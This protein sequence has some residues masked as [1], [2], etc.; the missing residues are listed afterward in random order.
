MAEALEVATQDQPV[1]QWQSSA[2]TTNNTPGSF[3]A[4]QLYDCATIH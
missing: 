2:A 4:S 1:S 3:G